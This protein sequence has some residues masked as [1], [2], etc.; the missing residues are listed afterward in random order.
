M[1]I[2]KREVL[3]LVFVIFYKEVL[4]IFLLPS[5]MNW[6]LLTFLKH[7][8]KKKELLEMKHDRNFKLLIKKLENKV[9]KIILVYLFSIVV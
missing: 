1:D 7:W 2:E 9:E 4:R 6:T 5:I 3:W 8:K